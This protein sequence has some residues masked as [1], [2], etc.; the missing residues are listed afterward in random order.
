MNI[1]TDDNRLI[2]VSEVE[3]IYRS[4]ISPK[5][6]PVIRSSKDSYDILLNHWE[7]DKIDFIEQFKVL[8][9]NRGNR[10]LAINELSSGGLTGT[11]AD[12]R[13]IF[14]TAL[15]INATAF[16]MA[17]NHPSGELS[18]SQAD[19]SLTEKI[20]NAGKFLDIR[21]TDHIIL[22]ADTY[23]SYADEGMI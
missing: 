9:L 2:I 6:R 15:K 3:L 19:T 18:P 20:K 21:L 5:L 1:F 4:K 11:V 8:Y 17:H 13:L 14:A 12:P 7:K 23:Y 16:I 10:V 22:S